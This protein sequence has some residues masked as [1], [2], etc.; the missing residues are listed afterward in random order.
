[1][2]LN[3]VIALSAMF[4]FIILLDDDSGQILYGISSSTITMH[5]TAYL[6]TTP[7]GM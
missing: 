4:V 6:L 7:G 2:F 5:H 3:I 1:M